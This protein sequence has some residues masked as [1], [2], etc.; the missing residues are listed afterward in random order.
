MRLRDPKLWKIVKKNQL[1]YFQL[2]T[3]QKLIKP[4][5]YGYLDL[6]WVWRAYLA[7]QKSWVFF[8]F[9]TFLDLGWTRGISEFPEKAV[10][11]LP[12]NYCAFYNHKRSAKKADLR[13][14]L[15]FMPIS[16]NWPKTATFWK[17]WGINITLKLV[18]S[19]GAS[20]IPCIFNIYGH[21]F[22]F[23]HT[24]FNGEYKK[25]WWHFL[26]AFFGGNFWSFLGS[27]WPILG[28][29][30]KMVRS[31]WNFI[32]KYFTPIQPRISY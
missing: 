22:G 25:V 20:V 29:K 18:I 26:G 7:E 6:I 17:I 4:G 24:K 1:L 28:V 3:S 16:Q 31:P 13:N 32:C 11:M 23:P 9:L 30:S 5:S 14:F 21:F 10:L 12:K 27:F 15:V 8:A 2:Q 19:A